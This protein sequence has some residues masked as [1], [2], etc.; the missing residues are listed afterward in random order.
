MGGDEAVETGNSVINKIDELT[1]VDR[2]GG[3]NVVPVNTIIKNPPNESIANEISDLYH[4]KGISSIEVIGT[5]KYKKWLEAKHKEGPNN[6]EATI[7]H[8]DNIRPN[9]RPKKQLENIERLKKE[10]FEPEAIVITVSDK[11]VANLNVAKALEA[12]ELGIGTKVDLKNPTEHVM[13]VIKKHTVPYEELK[14]MYP[15]GLDLSA[16]N[17][18]GETIQ[19]RLNKYLSPNNK[20]QGPSSGYTAVNLKIEV[21]NELLSNKTFKTMDPELYKNIQN[22]ISSGFIS[23]GWEKSTVNYLFKDINNPY[24]Y[25]NTIYTL[26]HHNQELWKDLNKPQ[27]KFGDTKKFRY[28][29]STLAASLGI[30][31][32]TKAEAGE[33]GTKGKT[34]EAKNNGIED[35]LSTASS[36]A[37]ILKDLPIKKVEIYDKATE[38]FYRKKD[39]KGLAE[40]LNKIP[41]ESYRQWFRSMAGI[42][43][44]TK[45]TEAS[46]KAARK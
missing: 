36:K 31:G 16:A 27:S 2:V 41:D 34:T 32:A 22:E 28:A 10:L 13:R 12:K 46:I 26:T 11:S 42:P 21:I 6:F 44:G 8:P 1:T 17:K 9:L 19:G 25:S 43:K 37:S 18:P 40:Y 7:G 29:M 35:A 30:A 4:V 5:A 23:M 14:T 38:V 3:D 45:I 15:L 20:L 24:E 33:V 39:A